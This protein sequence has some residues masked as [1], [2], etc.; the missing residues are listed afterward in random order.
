MENEEL[1]WDNNTRKPGFQMGAKA[2]LLRKA[3]SANGD[4]HHI[5][6]TMSPDAEQ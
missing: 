1:P 4:L 5:P 2:A 3:L 6:V